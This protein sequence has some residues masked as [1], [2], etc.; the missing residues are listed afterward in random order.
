MK[1]GSTILIVE[2]EESHRLILRKTLEDHGFNITMAENGAVGLERMR[3]SKIDLAIVDL[4]MPVM[5]G[6]EFTNWVKEYNPN[7][8]VIILTAHAENFSSKEIIAA[9]VDGFIHKPIVIDEL[10]RMIEKL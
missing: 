3:T 8:P 6:M 4:E 7:F 1:K 2:D 9:N 10:L 5:N